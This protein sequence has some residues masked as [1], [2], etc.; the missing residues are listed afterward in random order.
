MAVRLPTSGI[1]KNNTT[2]VETSLKKEPLSPEDEK[3]TRLVVIGHVLQIL[4][5]L[6]AVGITITACL[7]LTPLALIAIIP[8][9]GL[10]LLGAYV[11]RLPRQFAE[12]SQIAALPGRPLGLSNSGNNCFANTVLQF[13]MHDEELLAAA[14]EGAGLVEKAIVERRTEIKQLLAPFFN[15]ESKKPTPFAQ[16]VLG[17]ADREQLDQ[18]ITAIQ[19][20]LVSPILKGAISTLHQEC[21]Q[22]GG[23]FEAI[24]Q[25]ILDEWPQ[26][27]VLID[28]NSASEDRIEKTPI[29]KVDNLTHGTPRDSENGESS[30]YEMVGVKQKSSF[31]SSSQAIDEE[32][33]DIEVPIVKSPLFRLAELVSDYEEARLREGS[34]AKGVESGNLRSLLGEVRLKGEQHDPV[35]LLE[36]FLGKLLPTDLGKY[37]SCVGPETLSYRKTINGGQ[38]TTE[39]VDREVKTVLQVPLNRKNSK[40]SF[41]SLLENALERR[42]AAETKGDI[43]IE[44]AKE[45]YTYFL[46]A[47]SRL[48]VQL[49]RFNGILE[50]I[51]DQVENIISFELPARF[52]LDQKKEGCPEYGFPLR[53]AQATPFAPGELLLDK[54]EKSGAKYELEFFI[55]HL[56]GSMESGHYIAY[57]RKQKAKETVWIRMDDGAVSIVSRAAAEE[58][59]RTAYILRYVQVKK[60]EISLTPLSSPGLSSQGLSSNSDAAVL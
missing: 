18:V 19:K 4:A 21:L 35:E 32:D 7:T 52:C 56:G 33:V 49:K 13:V 16:A 26:R 38:A 11:S 37:H 39:S 15:W 36:A 30:T 20:K 41:P 3:T 5:S 40:F 25:A 57:A 9:I 10:H 28:Q 31:I 58:A 51:T 50:K 60:E 42:E 6:V 17:A 54:E 29:R 43:E 1:Q 53:D 55:S 14:K 24:K 27:L 48:T 47:P 22:K 46:G 8:C 12:A 44:P 23:E 34:M 45:E 2:S 59:A